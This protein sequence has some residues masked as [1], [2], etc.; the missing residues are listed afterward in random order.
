MVWG[1]KQEDIE[2]GAK[3]TDQQ[4]LNIAFTHTSHIFERVE[5]STK[6]NFCPGR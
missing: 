1:V 4:E 2:L 3:P 5:D 6:T